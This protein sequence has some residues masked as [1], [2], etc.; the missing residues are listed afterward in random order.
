MFNKIP[1]TLLLAALLL[2]AACSTKNDFFEEQDDT[3]AMSYVDIYVHSDRPEVTTRADEGT[4]DAI[5]PE[6]AI[7]DVQVWAFRQGAAGTATAIGYIS[8]EYSTT[9]LGNSEVLRM[10]F[11]TGDL[12]AANMMVDFYAVANTTGINFD[13]LILLA[14]GKDLTKGELQELLLTGNDFGTTTPVHAV[15][16][17]G[18]P[19]SKVV[20]DRKI[21]ENAGA[22]SITRQDIALRRAVSKIQFYVARKSEVSNAQILGFTLN[23]QLVSANE[24]L[25]P[26]T[27]TRSPHLSLT[28]TDATDYVAGF[29]Y[30]DNPLTQDLQ[31]KDMSEPEGLAYTRWKADNPSGT[32]QQYDDAL[33]TY[34]SGYGLTYLRETGKKLSGT[35]IYSTDGGTTTA[36][37]P[38]TM[39]AEGDFARNHSYIVYVYFT[40]AGV[41]LTV[42]TQPWEYV[43]HNTSYTNVITVSD[44]GRLTPVSGTYNSQQSNLAD[45]NIVLAYQTIL[46]FRFKIDAPLG[47]AWTATFN[48]RGGNARAFKF[49]DDEGGLHDNISGDIGEECTLRIQAADDDVSIESSAYLEIVVRNLMGSNVYVN[50]LTPS[51]KGNWTIIQRSTN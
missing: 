42:S 34:A 13:A 31:I 32:P 33:S 40:T 43:E 51:D 10:P 11:L 39:A 37:I 28:G 38:F 50:D 20:A 24:Y 44:A 2:L 49:V 3:P 14:K 16:A 12:D 48:S 8:R 4:V 25:L 5:S 19:M 6:D 18:L 1:H 30:T 22:L 23:N 46:Q 15:P 47:Y 9:P 27:D 35:I 45:Q 17:E 29:T 36:T 26:N 41:N 21:T 7:Y